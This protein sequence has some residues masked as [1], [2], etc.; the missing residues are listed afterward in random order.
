MLALILS[1]ISFVHAGTLKSTAPVYDLSWTK[2]K[3]S[4]K[5]ELLEINFTK[6]KCN[7]EMFRKFSADM[8]KFP[9]GEFLRKGEGEINFTWNG[10]KYHEPLTSHRRKLLRALPQELRRMKLENKLACSG[11]TK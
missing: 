2:D 1:L 4:Y 6:K 5:D 9:T 8:D 11:K 10:T 7:Q 3:I